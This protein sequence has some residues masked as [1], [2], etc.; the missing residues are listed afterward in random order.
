[1]PP[2]LMAW[3]VAGVHAGRV[4]A[5]KVRIGRRRMAGMNPMLHRTVRGDSRCMCTTRVYVCDAPNLHEHGRVALALALARRH[6][7]HGAYPILP[8]KQAGCWMSHWRDGG[9]HPGSHPL[10]KALKFG[11]GALSV[12]QR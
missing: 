6:T 4:G 9:Y 2:G 12:W 10:H 3:H 5:G 1:M 8:A 7:G 11:A